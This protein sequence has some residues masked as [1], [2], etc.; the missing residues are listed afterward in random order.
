[1][2]MIGAVIDGF[3]AE[4]SFVMAGPYQNKGYMTEALKALIEIIFRNRSMYRVWGTCDVNNEA[5]AKVMIKCG[6]R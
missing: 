5:S 1:M 6:M 2:G 4:V 3:K